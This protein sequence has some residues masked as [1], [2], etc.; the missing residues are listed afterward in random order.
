MGR[1]RIGQPRD[2]LPVFLRQVSLH[3]VP[4]VV[5]EPLGKVELVKCA[6]RRDALDHKCFGSHVSKPRLAPH[7]HPL[8]W[9]TQLTLTQTI[10]I[11]VVPLTGID[12]LALQPRVPREYHLWQ[13]AALS[14][15]QSSAR[16]Q[17]TRKLAQ[18]FPC[19]CYMI[20]RIA[21]PDAIK[22]AWHKR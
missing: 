11:A 12:R 14:D 6:Q 2:L 5:L 4:P 22:S 13:E 15:R 8:A 21:R 20:D 7:A 16:P 3:A 18:L 1:V 10:L 9:G 17:P 19:L